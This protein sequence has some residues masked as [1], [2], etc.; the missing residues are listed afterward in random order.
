MTIPNTGELFSWHLV[1]RLGEIQVLFPVVLGVCL[2]LLGVDATRPL[3]S[4]WL[5]ALLLAIVL[6]TASKIAFIG[7]GLG[8]E[9]W[10][11]TG[12]SGHAMM[13]SAIFP[14][15]V[16]TL[17]SRLPAGGQKMAV[18]C[19]FALVIAVGVSR[20]M[21]GAHSVSE[22]LAGLLVGSA[23]S[24]FAMAYQG[25]PRAKLN[26]Y[27]PLM[28]VPW[29]VLAPLQMPQLPTHTLVTRLSLLLS[30]HDK[31]HTRGDMHR[32]TLT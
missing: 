13:A 2:I 8:N 10:D 26:F 7:W 28:V 11:F 12:I 32:K 24:A 1:T 15:L 9:R 3:V 20:V 27:L 31:P 30:G 23:A 25:L 18:L 22:V 17:T 5:Q 21:V 6:T 16:A 19:S 29:L 4:R 14:L